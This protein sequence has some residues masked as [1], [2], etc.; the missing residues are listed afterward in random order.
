MF[1]EKIDTPSV[2]SVMVTQDLIRTLQAVH[3]SIQF[4]SKQI[5]VHTNPNRIR[6]TTIN[7]YQLSCVRTGLDTPSGLKTIRSGDRLQK[8]AVSVVESLDSFA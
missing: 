3:L 1:E 5:Y 2:E 7:K 6:A 4:F 8:N